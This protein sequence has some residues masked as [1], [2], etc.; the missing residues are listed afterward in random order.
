MAVNHSHRT[1]SGEV[2]LSLARPGD[3]PEPIWQGAFRL[4][5]G[6]R[7]RLAEVPFS[8][9]QKELVLLDILS[10]DE[11]LA[12][13]AIVGAPPFSLSG[14]RSWLPLVLTTEAPVRSAALMQGRQH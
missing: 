6:G 14:W 10:D 8:P 3:A 9:E 5:P 2:Q 7:S 1:R 12:N 4:D 11:H 13:H